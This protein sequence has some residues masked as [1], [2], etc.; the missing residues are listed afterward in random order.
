MIRILF[1]CEA[2]IFTALLFTNLNFRS[3]IDPQA[4]VASTLFDLGEP[5]PEHYME[6]P[7]KELIWRGEQLI[8][9]GKSVSPE[10][11]KGK[12]ISKYYTCTSCHNIEREDPNLAVV[13]QDA[14][15]KYAMERKIP[16]LQASTFWGMVNRE[17][18][19]NDD[20]ELKY[21][22]LVEPARNSMKGAINLCATVCSQGRALEIWEMESI[23]AYL[24]SLEMKLSD[25]SLTESELTQ[26][27]NKQIKPSE[28]IQLIKS[29]FLPK[30]PATFAE[31]PADKRVGYGY[32]GDPKLGKGIFEL[33]CQHC[34]RPN[35]ESD[36]IFEPN[37]LTYDWLLKHQADNSDKSFYQIIRKGTYSQYGHQEY[38]PHYTL[39]KMSDQQIE[40]LKAFLL[41]PEAAS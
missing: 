22:S 12:Y 19:Y 40:H 16:Y 38:M 10:G 28:K 18:W 25:L 7:A 21:G 24:W 33:G 13:D 35:G 26:L 27:E 15:L 32:E 23:V 29:K 8:K 6:N 20:Y 11:V 36:V 1:I 9:E 17:T 34:H 30:S 4:G 14:R 2:L 39:E 5:K 31:P 41:H 37:E 3:K